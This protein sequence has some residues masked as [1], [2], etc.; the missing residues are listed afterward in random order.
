MRPKYPT[1]LTLLLLFVSYSVFSESKPPNIIL[2]VADDLGYGDTTPYG[3]KLIETPNL[4]KLASEGVLLTSFYASG[5]VCSPSRAGLLTGRYPIRS[6]LANRTVAVDGAHGLPEA[7]ITIAEMV[8][9]LGYRTALIGKWHLGDEP[10]HWPTRH[11]FDY[12]FGLLHPNDAA[13]QSLYRNHEALENT[14]VQAELTT[15]FTSEAI[16]FIERNRHQPFLL[17]LSHTAPHIPL[18]PSKAFAGSSD[19]GDYGDVVQEIDHSLGEIMIAVDRSGLADT[20][21]ILF[22]SDNGPFPEG[23]AGVLRGGKGTGWDGAYRVPFIARLAG[24]IPAGAV[25][26]AITMNIDLLPTLARFTGATAPEVVIDG[27]DIFPVLQGVQQSPHE[28]LYFFNN[29]R[30]AAVRTQRWRMVLSDYPPWR[31]AQPILFDRSRDLYPMIFDMANDP[32]EQYDRTRD[33]P[34]VAKQLQSYLDTGR[35]E[36]ERYSTLP[37]SDM[38]SNAE[39]N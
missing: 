33:F 18:A 16:Q 15:Q 30:I 39:L 25:S 2:V 6:G 7:E 8:Q 32:G 24:V 9:A 4:E 35:K 27:R 21:L 5:N 38:Y 13:G 34:R 28:V 22:T 11:G 37:D 12:F 20:T 36:L 1:I 10:Q 31:D 19:A 17:Y 23:S 14:L 3:A 29:E 26:D